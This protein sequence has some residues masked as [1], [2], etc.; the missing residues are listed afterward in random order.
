MTVYLIKI[1]TYWGRVDVVVLSNVNCDSGAIMC[2]GQV[3][4]KL[5]SI[6]QVRINY[7]TTQ[8]R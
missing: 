7:E 8:S 2:M 5:E 1:G 3:V 4:L 6:G